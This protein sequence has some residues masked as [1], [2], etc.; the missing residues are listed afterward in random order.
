MYSKISIIRIPENA[1]KGGCGF[2]KP[3]CEEAS[4]AQFTISL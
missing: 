1:V 4:P 3:Y 2:W